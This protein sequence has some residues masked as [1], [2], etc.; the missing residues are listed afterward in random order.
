MYIDNNSAIDKIKSSR[1]KKYK[2]IIPQLIEEQ[3]QGMLPKNKKIKFDNTNMEY[4]N[5]KSKYVYWDK[6]NELCQRLKL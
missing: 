1:S 5:T 2:T 6:T 3:R 4:Q